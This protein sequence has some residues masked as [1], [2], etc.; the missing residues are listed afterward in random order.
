MCEIINCFQR[1]EMTHLRQF[2]SPFRISCSVYCNITSITRGVSG[3]G[4]QSAILLMTAGVPS[5]KDVNPKKWRPNATG[6]GGGHN[7]CT[8][9]SSAANSS[10]G[11]ETMVDGRRC[12]VLWVWEQLRRLNCVD[13]ADRRV[14]RKRKHNIRD[15]IS[16]WGRVEKENQALR[17]FWRGVSLKALWS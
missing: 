1:C 10:R 15:Q 16:R 2:H 14:L 6:D 17:S 7:R 8:G 12:W 13:S 5:H 4:G 11:W 9:D 3:K